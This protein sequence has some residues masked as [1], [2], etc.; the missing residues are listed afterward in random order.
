MTA[1]TVAM[2]EEATRKVGSL[3]AR[4]TCC[5][6]QVQVCFISFLFLYFILTYLYIIVHED[7]TTACH[8]G[9]EG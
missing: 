3:W 9:G 1:V 5:V 8:D 7:D 6:V 4:M 2:A